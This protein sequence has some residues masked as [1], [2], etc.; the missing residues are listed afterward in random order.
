VNHR[1]FRA[2]FPEFTAPSWHVWNAVED[3]IHGVEPSDLEL[4]R[5]ITGRR[6]L[7]SAPVS[8]FWAIKGRG[9]GGSRFGARLV[10]YC[11]AARSYRRVAGERI[12]AAVT[13]PDRRQARLTKD[14]IVG[15]LRS[16]PA[17][18]ALI[19]G[20]TS[21]SV[22]LSTGVVIEVI[23]AATATPRGRSYCVFVVEEAA[24]LPVEGDAEP[25]RELLRAVRPALARVPGSLLVVVS[26]PY[27][28][29][30]ELYRTW[31]ER[32]GR[33]D[34]ADV[35][36]M[37]ADTLTL[38]PTFSGREVERAYR[39]DPASAAAEYGA[40][41]RDDVS[42]F[43]LREALAAVVP[44]GV[45]ERAPVAGQRCVG[46]LDAATGSG[47]DA[48]AAAV[49]SSDGTVAELLCVRRWAPPFNP[50]S[51]AAEAAALFARYGVARVSID[52][53]AP[54]LVA[55]LLRRHGIEAVTQERDT[56]ATFVELLALINSEACLLLDEPQ[57]LAELGA[58]E[59]RALP[60]GRDRVGH[61][62]RGHDDVAAA[63]AGALV[64]AMGQ[65][66]C[67]KCDDPECDGEAPLC[68]IGSATWRE[69]H[70]VH[71][72]AAADETQ[73]PEAVTVEVDDAQ[74]DDVERVEAPSLMVQARGG[75]RET[76]SAIAARGRAAR[77]QAVEAAQAVTRA[78]VTRPAAAVRETA[79]AVTARATRPSRARIAGR[80]V[81]AGARVAASI[82]T[83]GGDAGETARTTEREWRAVVEEGDA[84][85]AR[86]RR[87]ASAKR[88]RDAC[89]RRGAWFP[90]DDD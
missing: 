40:Q 1:E 55:D 72:R 15:L 18:A 88:I 86:V 32:F 63:C 33:D 11:A 2:L 59:R 62:A 9:G 44:V 20:E 6:V 61:P 17:L 21:E 22:E 69:W 70:E 78:A 57:L 65:R 38:N 10:T 66:L 8:E 77:E 74:A 84:Y 45:R 35:L 37:Q 75:L 68:L 16:V 60:G 49:A 31:A 36:V 47:S 24:F 12:Y 79:A 58:L 64:A 54:G 39:D 28:K 89:E 82:I 87:E 43:L 7:P 29:R 19:V 73:E 71:G 81:V 25:D 42:T 51:V 46:H 4:V 48:M 5:R 85:R 14:Y 56:S 52:R 3:A 90:H 67:W 23:T 41:F 34:D 30:G 26:S 80:L 53:F 83:P 50:S 27:A 13:A 76:W